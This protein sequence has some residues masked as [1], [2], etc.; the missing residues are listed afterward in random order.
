MRLA[1]EN[2]GEV[3]FRG[4]LAGGTQLKPGKNP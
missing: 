2:A 1:I 4:E 3:A